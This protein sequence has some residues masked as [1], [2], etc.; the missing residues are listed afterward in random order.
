MKPYDESDL[1]PDE[2]DIEMIES[3]GTVLRE[4][5]E[6]KN[7]TLEELHAITKIKINNLEAMEQDRFE[8]IAAPTYA[9]GFLKICAK[10][11]DLDAKSLLEAYKKMYP[12]KD[13]S[14]R[15]LQQGLFPKRK[16]K[17]TSLKK[18]VQLVLVLTVIASASLWVWNKW[19]LSPVQVT[20]RPVPP[21][22]DVVLEKEPQLHSGAVEATGM[23]LPDKPVLL[24]L[25]TKDD[26]WL[27]VHA[28]EKLI[29]ENTLTA[30]QA[31]QWEADRELK[32]RI[33]RPSEV[34][35][36]VNGKKV[37]LSK[38][39]KPVSLIVTAEEV[40]LDD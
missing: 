12:E 19:S 20:A 11:L 14:V 30:N 1:I 36:A 34:E 27:K 16:K 21:T 26:V 28:D 8:R 3:L 9:K 2:N 23:V 35:L 17:K 18:T 37:D 29:F 39:N 24:E 31:R 32:L 40:K 33:G 4:A 6:A 10:A 7:L 13:K 5:R 38:E 22:P 25:K 15:V